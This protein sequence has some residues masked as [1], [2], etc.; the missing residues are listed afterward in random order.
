MQSNKDVIT[1]FRFSDRWEVHN[2]GNNIFLF[3]YSNPLYK[4]NNQRY[5]NPL[6]IDKDIVGDL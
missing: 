6:I 5:Y 2:G 1:I 3:D 4:W